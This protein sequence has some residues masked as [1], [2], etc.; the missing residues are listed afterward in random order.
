[1]H[2]FSRFNSFFSLKKQLF[3]IERSLFNAENSPFE[4]KIAYL[5]STYLLIINTQNTNSILQKQYYICH[6]ATHHIASHPPPRHI[7]S[8]PTTHQPPSRDASTSLSLRIEWT[9]KVIHSMPH[10]PLPHAACCAGWP[11]TVIHRTLHVTSVHMPCRGS[12]HIT[13]YSLF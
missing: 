10:T 6:H 11:T 13:I 5:E 3:S 2:L 8:H 1:M 4:R 9:T 7:S 12:L